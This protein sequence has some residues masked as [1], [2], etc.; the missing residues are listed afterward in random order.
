MGARGNFGDRDKFNWNNQ[1]FYLQEVQQ[2]PREW[3]SWCIL[4]TS[5]DGM[6]IK[7][8]S[9]KTHHSSAHMPIQTS[10]GS[11]ITVNPS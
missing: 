2:Q 7:Q 8:L 10:A 3:N 1:I 4:L 5:A 9:I 6:P 11:V